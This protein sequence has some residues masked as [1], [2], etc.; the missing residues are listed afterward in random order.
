MSG[1]DI[2]K[3]FVEGRISP[4]AFE[5]HL[6]ADTAL[7]ALLEGE[8]NLPTYVAEPDLYLYLISQDYQSLEGIYNVQTLLSEWLDRQG[9]AHLVDNSHQHR[10]TLALKGQPKWVSL[11]SV[12]I[13]RF[14]AGHGA[15]DPR[16]LQSALK[17]AIKRDFR[18]L[19]A[20]P[21]WLQ[22]PEWPL[23]DDMPMVFVGQL[24]ISGLG[25]DVGQA[26]L[27]FDAQQQRFHTVSQRC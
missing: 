11:P 1:V 5:Q 12:Y 7:Q 3:Q 21:K 17:E 8:R 10:F 19:K 24:D 9:V 14:M 18:C 22:A 20:P 25:H 6:H 2:I 27:F 13:D 15:L 23:A 16:A 26:Y 4:Q